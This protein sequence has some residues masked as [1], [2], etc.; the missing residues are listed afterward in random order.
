[1]AAPAISP[2]TNATNKRI[3][4]KRQD[5]E[6]RLQSDDQSSTLENWKITKQ[7]QKSQ[8]PEEDIQAILS[9]VSSYNSAVGK[10]MPPHLKKFQ[11]NNKK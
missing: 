7:E 2:A 3:W 8:L 9:S 11:I 5:F 10:A 1:M 6:A 4:F